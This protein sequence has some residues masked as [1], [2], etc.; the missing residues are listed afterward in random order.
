MAEAEELVLDIE[1][2][3]IRGR[4]CPRCGGKIIP[5]NR[6]VYQSTAGAGEAFPLWQCERC[7]YEQLSARAVEAVKPG[8]ESHAAKA[9]PA[10]DSSA[11]NAPANA[12]AATTTTT[13][14]M[15]DARGRA[16]PRDVQML[17][18]RMPKHE[19]KNT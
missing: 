1:K 7:G 19:Q 6:A 2:Q 5:S 4:A 12:T 14:H 9:I 10:K 18:E 16:L 13:A 11:A 15:R 3:S 17:L 8:K